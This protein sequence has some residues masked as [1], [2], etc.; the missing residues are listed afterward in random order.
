[1]YCR[2]FQIWKRSKTIIL[3]MKRTQLAHT[4]PVG[5]RSHRRNFKRKEANEDQSPDSLY[6]RQ[7]PPPPPGAISSLRPDQITDGG[8]YLIFPSLPPMAVKGKDSLFFDRSNSIPTHLILYYFYH[9]INCS[10][11]FS[12]TLTGKQPVHN[13]GIFHPDRTRSR[14]TTKLPSLSPRIHKPEAQKY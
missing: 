12:S 1:M 13:P 2:K 5:E 7:S 4:K 11:C 10:A 6:S 14:K 3:S 9:I 8:L